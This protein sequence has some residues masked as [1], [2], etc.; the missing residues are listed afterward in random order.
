MHEKFFFFPKLG[1]IFFFQSKKLRSKKIMATPRKINISCGKIDTKFLWHL[2]KKK[3]T[4]L[5]QYI[6]IQSS[7]CEVLILTDPKIGYS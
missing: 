1:K 5:I 2:Q 7:Y 6:I 4:Y 3:M